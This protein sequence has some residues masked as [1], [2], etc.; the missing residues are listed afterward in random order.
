MTTPPPAALW[1]VYPLGF[2]GA[3]IRRPDPDSFAS[4]PAHRLRRVAAWLDYAA[5]LG[6][7]GIVLGPVLLS[8]THG[9]DTLDYFR[10]DPRLGDEDDFLDLVRAAH[11]R[12]LALYGDG[13]FNHVS[14]DH[15][16]LRAALAGG[17]DSPGAGMFQVAWRAPG[18]PRPHPFEGH[19]ELVCFDH[20]SGETADFV[21]EVMDYWLSRGLDGFR[22]DAAYATGPKFWRRVLPGVRAAHPGAWFFAEVIHG[23]YASEVKAA[24]YDSLT[25]YELWKAIWSSLLDPNFFELDWSLKRHNR[26]LEDFAPVTFVSNHDVTRIASQVGPGKAALAAVI[27]M[28]VGGIPCVYSGDEQAFTGVKEE[29]VGGDDAV[30]P[31][32]PPD[33]SGLAPFGWWMYD[34]YRELLEL[35]R[36]NPWLRR[37][38][39][40]T[41]ALTTSHYAYRVAAGGGAAGGGALEVEVDVAGRPRALIRDWRHGDK[42]WEWEWSGLD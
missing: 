27:L 39:S 36:A 23:N 35:R 9:Y 5:N 22:L 20:A 31:E 6:V 10:I 18:G 33:P 40:T 32:F 25:Q 21:T 24:G 28:T 14:A 30:R 37:A 8:K 12:G 15:P 38:Q 7:D 41:Q 17:P 16:A 11:A 26:F 1:Y 2:T 13:V 29:R 19:G 3:P 42:L 34:L 4:A